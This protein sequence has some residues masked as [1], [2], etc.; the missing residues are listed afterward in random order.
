[1]ATEIRCDNCDERISTNK[2]HWKVVWRIGDQRFRRLEFCS[3]KCMGEWGTKAHE[4]KSK[5][6]HRSDK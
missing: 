4:K 2:G 3:V 6:C 1:M 5:S